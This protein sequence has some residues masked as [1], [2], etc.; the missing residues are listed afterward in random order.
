MLAIVS[1]PVAAPAVVG[2]N[3]TV[4]VAV[5]PAA[6]DEGTLELEIEKPV[7]DSVTELIDTAAVPVELNT[8]DCVAG[9]LSA[10]SPKA[11][12]VAFTVSVATDVLSESA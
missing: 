1:V 6:S 10:T 4:T 12:D 7:P 8:T 5:C 9:V 2:S 11:S 3:C